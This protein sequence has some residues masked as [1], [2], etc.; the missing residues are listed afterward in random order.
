M[1][2]DR[3]RKEQNKSDCTP[4]GEVMGYISLAR[5][6]L[7]AMQTPRDIPGD[8]GPVYHD[9]PMAYAVT[10]SG[11]DEEYYIVSLSFRPGT[12]FTGKAGQEQ[13]FISKEGEIA[14]RQVLNHPKPRPRWHLP[15]G[16]ASIAGAALIGVVLLAGGGSGAPPAI[17]E[18]PTPTEIPVAANVTA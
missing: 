5:A 1:A 16:I 6:R 3:N 11:E 9:V 15:V 18:I 17:A 13:F 8:Y 12:E 2:E 7:L 14:L 4:Q 10:E